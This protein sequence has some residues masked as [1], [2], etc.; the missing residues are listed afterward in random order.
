MNLYFWRT[1][2]YIPMHHPI[3]VT[4]VSY[5]SVLLFG[6]HSGFCAG[7]WFLHS[8][9][10]LLLLVFARS[11]FCLYRAAMSFAT[12]L[13]RCF[14]VMD[15]LIFFVAD[16]GVAAGLVHAVWLFVCLWSSVQSFDAYNCNQLAWLEGESS[17][18]Y[19]WFLDL[20]I[21]AFMVCLV[22]IFL[23]ALRAGFCCC[24]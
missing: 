18:W 14:Y 9:C 13:L 12:G 3:V 23:W 6:Y 24:D 17:L 20:Q 4:F 10:M 22:G 16:L 15:L 7:F 19:S 8:L 21:D 11:G 2:G 5:C 1:R